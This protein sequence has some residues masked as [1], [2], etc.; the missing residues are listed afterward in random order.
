MGSDTNRVEDDGADAARG[1]GRRAGE[2][3]SAASDDG[4]GG[5]G[6]D[7]GGEHDLFLVEALLDCRTPREPGLAAPPPTRGRPRRI[8]ASVS[9]SGH[10][11]G[12]VGSRERGGSG[13]DGRRRHH[14]ARRNAGAL[15]RE[16]RT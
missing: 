12:E 13:G 2:A 8:R 9:G 5:V 11:P 15:L 7:R 10:H 1:E 16:R 14:T 4:D 3:G 6:G